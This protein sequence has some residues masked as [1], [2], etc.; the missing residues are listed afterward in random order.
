MAVRHILTA[1]VFFLDRPFHLTRPR[2]RFVRKQIWAPDAF[3]YRNFLASRA[4][5]YY[6]PNPVSGWCIKSD[7]PI[8]FPR[9][10]RCRLIVRGF[11]R[12]VVRIENGFLI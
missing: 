1:G 11:A 2:S 9:G 10:A 12:A 7:I 4:A 3:R 8:V 6:S 5:E